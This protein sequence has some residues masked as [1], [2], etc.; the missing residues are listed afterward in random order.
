MYKSDGRWGGETELLEGYTY[1]FLRNYSPSPSY[2]K[3]P[4]G[5]LNLGIW[6]EIKRNR[7]DVVILM[8]W[9]N[10]TW[11]LAILACRYFRIP[12]LYMTDANVLDDLTINR[13]KKWAKRIL[14]GKIL[15]PLTS[16]FLCSGK[17]NRQLYKQY[18]VPEGKLFEFAYSWGYE[19]LLGVS[20][21]L[22]SQKRQLR[23]ELGIPEDTYLILFC[24]RLSREKGTFDLLEAFGRITSPKKAL[25]FVGDGE[26]KARLGEHI[27]DH[28][29]DGVHFAGFQDRVE[30]LK[31]Y[32]ISDVLVLPSSH[33]PW[34][35]VVN[36]AMCFGIPII[37][38]EQ[39]GAGL[40]LVLEGYNG[41]VFPKGDV[42]AL[43]NAFNHLMGLPEEEQLAMGG[44]SKEMIEKWTQKNLPG[45]LIHQ[46]DAI[47]S[48]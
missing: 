35:M 26:L 4:G 14:L 33:E 45:M 21:N 18:G 22:K 7:P 31:Y 17:A 19:A 5:L 47:Y 44:R 6:S 37:V 16:G 46:L 8:S 41:Y 29:L 9:M 25:V 38:S 42:E 40:D 43:V 48:R 30:L 12:F 24:G 13:W 15:F 11:W 2:L 27:A 34:G 1:K 32:A 10:A 23:A 20:D 39:V 28:D 3:W 36:E